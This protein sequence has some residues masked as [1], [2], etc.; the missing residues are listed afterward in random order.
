VKFPSSPTLL[1]IS[2]AAAVPSISSAVQLEDYLIANSSYE[3]A[4]L[5]GSFSANDAPSAD[6]VAYSYSL[7]AD[8]DRT[9]STLPRSWTYSVAATAQGSRGSSENP[10][11]EEG[12]ILDDSESD[13][14]LLARGTIDTYF[15]D[16]KYPQ[17][18]WFGQG[19]Y[20]TRDSSPDDDISVDVG[21]G[22][23]RVYNAT[24]LAKVLRIVEELNEEG[25][26]TGPIPDAIMIEAAEIVDRESEFR[27]KYGDDEYRRQ[28]YAAIE[29]ALARSEAVLDGKLG[30]LGALTMDEILEEEPISVRKH[31]WVARVGAGF[32]AS[33]LS[34]LSDND[35][36]LLFSYEYAKP[37]G[38]RGQ[39]INLLR[40]EPIFGDS[41]VQQIS[42]EM[43]YT[44]EV[45]DRVD[46]E[47][48]WKMTYRDGEDADGEDVSA[49]IHSL[50]SSYSYF[51][52]NRLTFSVSLTATDDDRVSGGPILD[53]LSRFKYRLK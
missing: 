49:T 22:Y 8:Y 27:S 44:H 29:A 18:F 33:D 48:S 5:D 2:I 50:V 17:A 51:L 9:F 37:Y 40:Y 45:S 46:W 16:S 31:G 38:Y 20:Q 35:P 3:E 6:Q 47:N 25:L 36:K 42:N 12:N 1:A 4:Y 32:Q 43:S 11:D 15:H 28:F 34:G 10:T 7:K 52:T 30:A 21:L 26:L 13:Y 24:P 14:G 23:G 53:L 39:F 19:T 41:T